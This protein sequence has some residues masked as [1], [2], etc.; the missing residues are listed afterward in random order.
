MTPI[1]LLAIVGTFTAAAVAAGAVAYMV[2]ER[3]TPGRQRLQAV[4]A[5]PRRVSAVPVVLAPLS[6]TDKPTAATQ[7]I[8]TFVPKSPAEMSK[9]RRRLVRAGY[10]SLK[11]ALVFSI[12]EMVLPLVL[13]LPM[14]VIF[15]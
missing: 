11:S 13:G 12:A 7:R 10:H 15:G 3:Q 2:L 8:A 4:M 1:L 14:L 9:L 6:L 5:G